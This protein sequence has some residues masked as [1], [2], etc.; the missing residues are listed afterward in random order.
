MIFQLLNSWSLLNILQ[1]CEMTQRNVLYKIMNFK[2]LNFFK[3][4]SLYSI[5][6]RDVFFCGNNFAKW[7]FLSKCRQKT[8]GADIPIVAQT[9]AWVSC[10]SRELRRRRNKVQTDPTAAICMPSSRSQSSA[11][12]RL[13]FRISTSSLFPS[14][15]YEI[16]LSLHRD[17]TN[18][19]TAAPADALTSK[20]LR[21]FAQGGLAVDC[22]QLSL[23]WT[24]QSSTD[25]NCGRQWKR[26]VR[27]KDTA[28]LSVWRPPWR[29]HCFEGSCT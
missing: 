27:T 26:F 11:H 3:V 20:R 10:W 2:V 18:L 4:K 22:E 15:L 23:N 13:G 16:S 17:Q 6:Y 28:Q 24:M 21:S 5:E 1:N 12:K 19:W 8:I 9:D 25:Y 14:R 29:S 7:C